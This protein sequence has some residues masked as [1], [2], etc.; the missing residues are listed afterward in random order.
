VCG[1]LTGG[2]AYGTG[3]EQARALLHGTEPVHEGF[4]TG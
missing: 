2:H 1:L 4:A 3:Y